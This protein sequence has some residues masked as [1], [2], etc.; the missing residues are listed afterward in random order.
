MTFRKIPYGRHH[1]TDEDIQAVVETLKSDFLTQGPNVEVFEKRF[2]EYVDA[3]YAIAVSNGTAALH[4]SAIALEVRK[5]DNVIVPPITFAASANC[6]RYCG[7]DVTF[8]D[9][10]KNTYLLDL[11][12]LKQLLDSKPKGFF[13][14]VIPVDFAGYPIHGEELRQIADD[15]GLWI[16][17]DAC[18]APGAFFTD[19]NGVQQKIGNGKFA[20]LTCFSF[21]PVKHIATGEGG[22]ITTNSEELYNRLLRLRTHGITKDE[23]LMDEYHGRWY[24]EMQELG[25]NYR[26][27]EFQAALGISQLKRANEGLKRRQEIAQRYNEAFQNIKQIE[28]PKVQIGF[29]HASHLY[30]IQVDERKYLYEQLQKQNIF[31]QIHYIPVHLMPYY[32][33]FGWKHGDMPIAEDFYEH[34]LSLP[35]YPTLTCEEQDYVINCTLQSLKK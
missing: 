34:C 30:V 10:D 16:I 31:P 8:C 6:I 21:H 24:Y 32:K 20:E 19:K 7:G 23:H 15:Y 29:F 5:S 12:A 1:I 27:T 4:L 33:Q 2:A 14:G 35:M 28:T 26:M 9:I 25:Y 17:E 11:S 13:K 3:K 18:H 22:M